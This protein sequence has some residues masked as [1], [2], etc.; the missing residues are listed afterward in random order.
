[1]ATH[2]LSWGSVLLSIAGCAHHAARPAR[3]CSA[4]SSPTAPVALT[5][6]AGSYD[7][8]FTATAGHYGNPAATGE[9]H[10]FARDSGSTI[11]E[12]PFGTT[13]TDRLELYFGFATIDLA[14][15]GGLTNGSVTSRDSVA[16]GV[17]LRAWTDSAPEPPEL[18]FGSDT[19]RRD[20]LIFDGANTSATILETTPSGIRGTWTST[21]GTTTY[22]VSGFFC[23]RRRP[24]AGD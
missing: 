19:N 12:T 2:I 10:L 23:A 22:R 20:L 8:A 18:E 1:M 6:L 3:W 4:P 16:P 24:P 7:L 15:V 11:I 5:G 14:S 17:V 21:I 13:Y 9:L